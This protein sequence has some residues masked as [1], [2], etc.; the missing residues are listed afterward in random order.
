MLDRSDRLGARLATLRTVSHALARPLEAVGVVRA[1]YRELAR[2]LDVTI[3]L[4][5]RYDALGQSVEVI[6][7]VHE[8]VELPGGQFPLGD[9]STSQVIRH[10]QPRLIRHWSEEGPRVQLQYATA[11]PD[12]PESSVTV[13]VVFDEQVIGVLALQSYRPYAYDEDDLALVQ[14][15]ADLVAVAIA[16]SRH[17]TRRA[18]EAE[19]RVLE[20]ESILSCLPDALLVV[21][22]Q[23]RLVRINQAARK[24]LC[25][26]DGS[27]ILGHPLDLPQ[28]GLW[29]LGTRSL[30]RQITPIVDQ[31]KRGIAPD[32]EIRISLDGGGER[33]VGCKASV[34][35]KGGVPA[36]G[37]MI[38]REQAA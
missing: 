2:S 32:D 14:G 37:L 16:G 35:V 33:T 34:L 22:I 18:E 38:F 6:W 19:V 25:P 20:V 10:C 8:G 12:L 31:L 1:V 9:G 15:V 4:F 11:R 26:S 23:G 29:P 36:G 7:Q 17:A 13:P 3:C 24:L 30:T 27:V 21:D 28:D 5:G